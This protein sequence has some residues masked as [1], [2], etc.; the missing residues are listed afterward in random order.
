[1][2]MI[3]KMTAKLAHILRHSCAILWHRSNSGGHTMGPFPH[4]A[5][6][7]VIGV[8]NPAGTDGFEFVEFAHPKPEE[9]RALFARMGFSLVARH[10]SKASELWQQGDITYV[11]NDEPGSHAR[12]FVEEHGPCA[13][14]MAWRVV[15]ARHAFDH[16]V[17]NG[18]EPYTGRIGRSTGRPSWGSA[19]R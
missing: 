3:A 15:D 7:A 18:A 17:R 13:P 11:L 5:P 1:M 2:R 19:G 6:R 4:H 9:A 14:A 8:E 10:R 12:R 16:A